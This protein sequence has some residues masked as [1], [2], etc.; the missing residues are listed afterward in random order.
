MR[1]SGG[2]FAG[3]GRRVMAG[4]VLCVCLVSL[5][6][7]G[8]GGSANAEDVDLDKPI[9]AQ[10]WEI[11]LTKP[12]EKATVVGEGGFTSQAVGTYIIVLLRAVNH[13]S[14]IR[15]FPARLLTIQDGEGNV[16]K[17]TGSTV[18]FN[19]ARIRPGVELLLDSPMMGIESRECLLIFDVPSGAQ[20]L[21][22][23]MEGVEEALRLGF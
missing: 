10:G 19:L 13:E 4:L 17:P 11:T 22:L 2:H 9:A 1:T 5:A 12:P 8:G 18:Q 15:L 20:D 7:C 6:A 23:H 21:T 3:L 16:Y 14:D